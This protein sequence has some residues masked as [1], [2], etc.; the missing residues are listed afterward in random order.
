MNGFVLIMLILLIATVAGIAAA[1]AVPIA[2]S[3][4]PL[5]SVL[6]NAWVKS[7][8]SWYFVDEEGVPLKNRWIETEA[9][10]C[11]V[12]SDG[13]RL[14]DTTETID[15]KLCRFDENGHYIG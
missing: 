2:R 11:Y 13:V 9:G 8:G 7:N 12:G 6:K 10:P 15:G 4:R 5:R 14:S 1:V 3:R